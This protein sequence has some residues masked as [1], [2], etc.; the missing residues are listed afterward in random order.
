[1]PD[2]VADIL[3]TIVLGP[4]VAFLAYILTVRPA[5]RRFHEE[6]WWE[7][8]QEVY[9]RLLETLHY[10]KNYADEHYQDQF[11]PGQMTDEKRGELEQEWKRSSREFTK[12]RDLASFHL[13]DEAL[14]IL[15]KYEKKKADTQKSE[16]LFRSI[17][18]D[19]EATAECLEK[20]KNAAKRDLKVNR[21]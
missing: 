11:N 7:K 4:I 3:K 19:L 6:K 20:L 13:S 8:K 17:E 14:A 5:I 21:I 12:L 10:L 16:D 9:L 2:W 18:G 15:D 1:M